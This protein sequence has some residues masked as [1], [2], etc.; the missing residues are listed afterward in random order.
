MTSRIAPARRVAFDLLLE[1]RQNPQL[2]SDDLLRS[3]RVSALS[4]AD[5]NLATA[6]VMGVLRWEIALDQRIAALLTKAKSHLPEPVELAVEL[7]A[8]QLL[9][10][11]RIPAHAA[12]FES[13][14]IAKESGNPHAAGMVNAVLRKLA[15]SP[16]LATTPARN[17]S[18]NEI[19]RAWAHPKWM[20]ERW[21]KE[22]G[23]AAAGA[24]CRYDQ[25]PPPV[26]V[27]LVAP[28]AEEALLSEG[29]KLEP[30]T[31]V[32][33]ARRVVKGDVSATLAFAQ[34][35][36]RIQDE[37]SQL[38]AEVA[39]HRLAESRTAEKRGPEPGTSNV[40]LGILD[41]CAAP[42]GKTAILAERNPNLPILACDVS[43]G[44]LKAMKNFLR[45]QRATDHITYRAV[46][47]T[48]LTYDR[49]FAAVLCDA[50]CSG[51]GTLAR[52][53]EIR[54]RLV[55]E[56]LRRQQTRQAR[57]LS[58]AM[59]A[60]AIGGRLVYSTCSLE[61][62]ENEIVIRQALESTKGFRLLSWREQMQALEADGSLHRGSID[63]LQA[64]SSGE[65]FLRTM[66][67][68]HPMDGFFAA[69]LTRDT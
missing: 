52:N 64:P 24:I 5:R 36:V 62:E 9:L 17:T 15:G 10:L 42:G 40:R 35:M 45:R 34:G 25:F 31:F 11:D 20:V 47:A 37:A 6:L 68:T 8:L 21:V 61:P 26:T 50:P 22:Y 19:A 51:T 32:C 60:L 41:C 67:G 44:R 49:E 57:L 2:H 59:R 4:S 66:P 33:Q 13:V 38:V 48:E 55:V 23:L 58:A 29:I 3:G 39:A 63:L 46:D 53:P 69:V 16:K 54:H 28:G 12:I 1:L 18:A 65:K 14:E 56:D 27:R 43:S 7:G 30:A